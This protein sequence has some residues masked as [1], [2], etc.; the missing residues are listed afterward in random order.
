M[1]KKVKRKKRIIKIKNILILVGILLI[2][3]V[4]FY[5]AFTMPIQNIYVKGNQTVSEKEIL[6]ESCLDEYP[7]F[8]LTS[9]ATI[10]K[11]ILKN[12]YIR[13]VKIVKKFGNVI[14]LTVIEYT[15]IAIGVDGNLILENGEVLE[16]TYDIQDVPLLVKNIDDSDVLKKFATCFGTIQ[17]DI[18]RQISQIE[19]SPVEVDEERFLLYMDD[20]NLVYITLTK[21]DQLNRYNQI[22]DQLEGK[23][24][25]IYLDAGNYV[26]LKK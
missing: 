22:K 7:S 15:V 8:L 13:D 2:V 6:Q 3:G 21:I 17:A 5:F 11:R 20:G 23:N 18:L 25:I 4:G 19:Y 14:E 1:A 16:N 24:G 26:E 9:K 12:P 10:R